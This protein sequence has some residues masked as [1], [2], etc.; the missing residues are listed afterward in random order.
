MNT[1]REIDP[2][3]EQTDAA[4]RY[5]LNP[6]AKHCILAVGLLITALI[7]GLCLNVQA[8]KIADNWAK[9]L[10]YFSKTSQ[11]T[12]P[13]TVE[14]IYINNFSNSSYAEKKRIQEQMEIIKS[15]STTH[16]TIMTYFYTRFY[17]SIA[18]ASVSAIISAISL[19]YISKVGWE[20]ANNYI[21][22][23]FVTT[24]SIAIFVGAFP[25]VFQQENNIREN[26]ELY[27]KYINLENQILTRLATK[28]NAEG[29]NLT[30]KE[31]INN[32]DIKLTEYN[33]IA[34]GFDANSIP[35]ASDV[36]QKFS[37]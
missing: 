36:F 30:L 2:A 33:K 26:S 12:T 31:I 14:A 1:L 34:I 35:Q 17:M 18:L 27:L 29:T 10:K 4:Q 23:I 9:E 25:V 6:A 15:R 24:T 8:E 16:L 22:P 19:F 11:K 28:A 37:K 21:I 3:Q 7:G 32:T 13:S 5:R 20:K